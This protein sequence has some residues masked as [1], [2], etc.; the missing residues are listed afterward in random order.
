[1]S[2]DSWMFGVGKQCRERQDVLLAPGHSQNPIIPI[3]SICGFQLKQDCWGLIDPKLLCNN[4]SSP[5][6][7]ACG[8]LHCFVFIYNYH[9]K[10]VK[11][12]QTYRRVLNT[13]QRIFFLY[14]KS[15]LQPNVL[16]PPLPYP[17]HANVYFLET[18]IFSC[19]TV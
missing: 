1:M 18:R 15:K 8:Y 6:N 4:L 17:E 3:R 5:D 2:I 9:F 11:L 14:F 19:R 13:V 10:I 16:S 12:L 7:L